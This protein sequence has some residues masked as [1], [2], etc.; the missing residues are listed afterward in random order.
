[1]TSLK[2][3]IRYQYF[4]KEMMAFKWGIL[5]R[6]FFIFELRDFVASIFWFYVNNID[7]KEIMKRIRLHCCYITLLL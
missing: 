3:L 2:G 4:T 1:M 6:I 7:N 5:L